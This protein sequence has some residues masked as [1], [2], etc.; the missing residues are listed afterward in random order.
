MS[1]V[2]G[3]LLSLCIAIPA[4]LKRSLTFSGAFAA[5]LLGT[6]LFGFGE[7]VVYLSLIVFFVSSSVL[8][9]G[10]KRYASDTMKAVTAL[11][12]KNDVRDHTQAFANAG[13]ALICAAI[14]RWSGENVFKIASVMAFAVANADT[15]ASEIGV[16]STSKPVYLIKR[17]PV[18]RGISGGVTWLGS[19]ASLLGALLIGTFY[20]GVELYSGSSAGD[21]ITVGVYIVLIGFMGSVIDSLIGE[22]W[23]AKYKDASG[24]ITERRKDGYI[25]SG[26]KKIDNN[27]V[28]FVSG[29]LSALLGMAVIAGF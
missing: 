12:E 4:F 25:I 26:Y 5:V 24:A 14:Y 23:Q 21:A 2:L 17:T 22:L 7:V 19:F 18:E 20:V 11:L 16:L 3:F 28:N 10:V 13:V 29:L 15:W 27:V 6:L 1:Y 8:S 9:K